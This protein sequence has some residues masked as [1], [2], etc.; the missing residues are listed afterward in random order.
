[1]KVEVLYHP[2]MYVSH[3]ALAELCGVTRGQAR[4]WSRWRQM[5]V[6]HFQKGGRTRLK[7]NLLLFMD[8]AQDAPGLLEELGKD[9]MHRV[10]LAV[11]QRIVEVE[12]AI[13][14]KKQR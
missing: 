8:W 7:I 3:A 14:R 12:D 10:G 13:Q 11:S 2:D 5:P 9:G 6:H 1:M 4:A